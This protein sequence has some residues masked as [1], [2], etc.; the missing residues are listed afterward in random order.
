MYSGDWVIFQ[1]M[2]QLSWQRGQATDSPVGSGR[3]G[4]IACRHR[5]LGILIYSLPLPYL[6]LLCFSLMVASAGYIK[7]QLSFGFVGK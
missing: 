4:G 6:P 5:K 2:Q 1:L 7:A 3:C